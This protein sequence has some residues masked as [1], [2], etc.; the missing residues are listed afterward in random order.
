MDITNIISNNKHFITL[1]TFQA[2]LKMLAVRNN[3]FRKKD[4]QLKS[5]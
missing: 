1:S 3:T 4:Y 5:F 2:A